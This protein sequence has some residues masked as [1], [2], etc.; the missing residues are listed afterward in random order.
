LFPERL[1][2]AIA[3]AYGYRSG[4]GAVWTNRP[5]T[6]IGDASGNPQPHLTNLGS[7]QVDWVTV[8]H[9]AGNGRTVAAI[10]MTNASTGATTVW[11]PRGQKILSNTGA[12]GLVRNL[13]M[14]WEGCCDGNGDPYLLRKVVEPTPVFA[15]G[16]LYYLVS[17]VPNAQYL[18]TPQPVDQTVI[19]DAERAT[20]VGQYDHSDPNADA[21]IRA[22]F[23]RSG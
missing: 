20:I 2:R 11:T 9:P 7:G 12:A 6:E 17:V 14:Q 13:P 16:R 18:A 22:F 4:A 1:T 3:S 23:N 10:F 15:N 5:R 21:A 19:V 8:T